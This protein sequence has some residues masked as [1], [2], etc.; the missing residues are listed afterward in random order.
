M[1]I[2][3]PWQIGETTDKLFLSFVLFFLLAIEFC[4]LKSMRSSSLFLNVFPYLSPSAGCRKS[5]VLSGFMM[6]RSHQDM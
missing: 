4:W 2:L 1:F 3:V 6:T 5:M